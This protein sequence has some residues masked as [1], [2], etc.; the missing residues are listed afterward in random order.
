M[1]IAVFTDTYLPEINGVAKT[2]GR[3]SRHLEDRGIGYRIFAPEYS[4]SEPA[5]DAA[6]D[7]QEVIR[8][9]SLGFL[10]YPESRM[11]GKVIVDG[12]N[13][14]SID[15][16]LKLRFDYYPVGIRVNAK[17]RST[18]NAAPERMRSPLRL[19]RTKAA[20]ALS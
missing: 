20:P 16:M 14:L 18:G 13:M 7:R 3:L 10:L 5:C 12:R 19:G 1:K 2:L 17:I 8:F 6:S 9:Q 4:G 11:Q 15:K